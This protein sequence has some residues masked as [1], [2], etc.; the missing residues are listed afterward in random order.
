MYV[1]RCSCFAAFA[2]RCRL[3]YKPY[4]IQPINRK[5]ECMEKPLWPRRRSFNFTIET[6]NA[7]HESWSPQQQ[8]PR[9]LVAIEIFATFEVLS[10]LAVRP[11]LKYFVQSRYPPVAFVHSHRDEWV[12]I[13]CKWNSLTIETDNEESLTKDS[14]DAVLDLV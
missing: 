10:R 13:H 12:S 4:R 6:V 3:L 8:K 11:S 14:W 7:E 2:S 5:P 9:I 1:P